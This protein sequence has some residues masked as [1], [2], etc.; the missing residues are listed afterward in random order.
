VEATLGK[1]ARNER[2][3]LR[4]TF[5]NNLAVGV[6]LGGLFIPYLALFQRLD[7]VAFWLASSINDRML[8]LSLVGISK[9]LYT[10]GSFALAMFLA[11]M[12][13]KQAHRTASEIE[14]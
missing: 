7:E 10:V 5:F 9:A 3:K 11:R 13:L 12:F 1:A 8:S 14:D 4:A 6:S 2:R